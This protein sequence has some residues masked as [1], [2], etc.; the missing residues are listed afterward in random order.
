MPSKSFYLKPEFDLTKHF[1]DNDLTK[2]DERGNTFLH[3]LMLSNQKKN[4]VQLLKILITSGKAN[5]N[6][7]NKRGCTALDICPSDE[8]AM[9]LIDNGAD[10]NSDVGLHQKFQGRNK[11]KTGEYKT[12][13]YRDGTRGNL[14]PSDWGQYFDHNNNIIGNAS[15]GQNDQFLPRDESNG[16]LAVFKTKGTATC[17]SNQSCDPEDLFNVEAVLPNEVTQDW[18]EVIDEPISIKNR[19]LINITK[20][21]GVT[22]IGSFH[23]IASHDLRQQPINPKFVVSPWNNSSV[24]S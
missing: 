14:G 1:E 15:S 5:L 12:V 19:N 13:D 24:I 10:F 2:V 16:G 11:A 3:N 6:I 17:G 4:N 21:I 18:F 23:K 22:S 9:L 7:T 20:P 8:I